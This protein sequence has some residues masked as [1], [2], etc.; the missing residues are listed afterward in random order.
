[1]KK[2]KQ[3]VCIITGISLAGGSTIAHV[4]LCNLLNNNEFDCTL[5]GPHDWPEDK[6]RF[7]NLQTEKVQVTPESVIIAH[8]MDITQRIASK[9]FILTCHETNVFNLNELVKAERI[10]LSIFDHIHFVSQSQK[11]WHQN[12]GDDANIPRAVVIPNIVSELK[13]CTETMTGVAGI[14][15]SLDPH[16][17]PHLSI[18]R[19][20]KDGHKKVL[21]FGDVSDPDYFRENVIPRLSQKVVYCGVSRD[22]QPMYD[23]VGIVYH[24]SQRETFNY[25]EAECKMTGTK[26]NGLDTANSKAEVWN[27]SRILD[28]WRLLLS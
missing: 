19:A 21:I 1:M 28:S 2:P 7:K 27:E 25:I 23:A 24:S 14:I 3:S 4:N 9:K 5:Y 6:C 13:K 26:Y 8:F 11:E 16:K 18:D 20:L 22:I 15:G 17:Q 10:S 12:A